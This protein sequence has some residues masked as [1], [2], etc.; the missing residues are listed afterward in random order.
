MT[1]TAATVPPASGMPAP[2]P[3]AGE[4]DALLR[5]LRLPHIRRAAPEVLAT[6]RAQRWEPAEVLRTLLAAEATGRERSSRATRRRRPGSRPA[7][8]SPPGTSRP[9]RSRPRPRPPCGPWRGS[10]A[11]RTSWYAARQAP[12]RRSSSRHSGRQRSRPAARSPGSRWSRWGRW[13]A[14][15]APTTRSPRPSGGSCALTWWWS[16]YADILIGRR[17]RAAA[18]RPRRRRG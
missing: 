16:T 2:P 3:L 7:R 8:R 10:V 17:H 5:R 18:R 12:A 4:L 9:P 1:P 11:A 15:T 14:A 6:A 13:C